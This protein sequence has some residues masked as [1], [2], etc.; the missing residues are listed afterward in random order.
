MQV[1]CNTS[2]ACSQCQAL[3]E[4]KEKEKKKTILLTVYM[5]KGIQDHQDHTSRNKGKDLYFR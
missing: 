1:N 4:K 5:S 2:V 3:G